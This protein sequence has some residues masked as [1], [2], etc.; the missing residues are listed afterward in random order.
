MFKYQRL[1]NIWILLLVFGT[2]AGA[3]SS[4]RPYT[5]QPIKTFDPDNRDIPPPAET[6]EHFSWETLY[7]STFYQIEKPLKLSS[8][9]QKIGHAIGI[10]DGDEAENV[11]VL[12]EVPNSSWYTRRHYF[13][14]M[15]IAELNDGPNTAGG[16]DTTQTITVIRGKSEGVTPGFNI[17]D[18][19]G[20][21]F[22]VKLDH[23][24]FAEMRSSSEVIATLIY[25]ASGYYTPQNTIAYLDPKN[26]V[27]GEKATITLPDER[28]A[29]TPADL[30]SIISQAYTRDDG[31]VR[32]LA[33]KFVEGQ[34]L[35]P[36]RFWGKR[37]DD[38]NDRVPHEDRR[39]LRGLR[40]LASWLNDTDRRTANTLAS[41]IEE[42]GKNYIR[43]YLLDMGSTLGT[44]GTSLN[45]T[46]RGQEYRYDPRYMGL[47]YTTMGFYVKPWALPEAGDRPFY[48]SVGYYEVQLFSPARWVPSYPNPAFEKTTARDGFWG[49]KMVMAFSDEE[50]RAIVEEAELTNP[51]AK[52]YLI[53]VMI[54]R[55][56]K[57]G[58]YWF[59]QVNPLDKFAARRTGDLVELSFSD[60]AVDGNLFDSSETSYRYSVSQNGELL[61]QNQSAPNPSLEI[62]FSAV[63]PNNDDEPEILKVQILTLRN[64][65]PHPDKKVVVYIALEN[66]TPRVVGIEREG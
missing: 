49:A 62:P 12:D 37:K 19:N 10:D 31:K 52:E 5:L 58:R 34:P 38:P 46:K 30:D 13:E 29:M 16:P 66:E 63:S 65:S 42:D 48:P 45:H 26:L 61:L 17:R 41:Y 35:G 40:V 47:L 2:V 53:D 25:Y 54:A 18:A 28:R 20:D 21:V 1:M 8:T 6:V 24:D 56:D 22:V 50:I 7:L 39:E 27:V 15:S 57:I 55:R 44:D 51:E 59:R 3:C 64:G 11:N 4:S 9:F 60:L 14:P 33:S 36:W 43:H 23:P 32:V